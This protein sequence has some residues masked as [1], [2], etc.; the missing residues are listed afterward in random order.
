MPDT[1]GVIN[2]SALPSRIEQDSTT[3][4]TPFPAQPKMAHSPWLCLVTQRE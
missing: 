3:T 4:L 1:R 2:E